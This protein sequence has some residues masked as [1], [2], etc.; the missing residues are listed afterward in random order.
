MT[1]GEKRWRRGWRRDGGRL[2]EMA[3]YTVGRMW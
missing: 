1:S 3:V 2:A